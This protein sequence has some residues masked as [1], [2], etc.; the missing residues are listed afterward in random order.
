MIQRTPLHTRIQRVLIV[1][2]L[3]L[4]PL[5][6]LCS[7]LL[8]YNRIRDEYSRTMHTHINVAQTIL[9]EELRH[10]D[11]LVESLRRALVNR[12][13][14]ALLSHLV[15]ARLFN[16]M[17]DTF[18][19][20]DAEGRVIAI[21][22][23]Y[24]EY[25]G[26]DFSALVP[27][28]KPES[29][30]IRY[31]QSLLTTQSVVAI[32]YPFGKG[33]RLVVERPADKFVP[34]MASFEKAK[35]Y[36]GE[37]FFVLCENGLTVYHPDRELI[38]T[39]YNFGFE[40]K[41]RTPM[42]KEGFFT[43]ISHSVKYLAL[44]SVF[45]DPSNW[46]MYYAIPT[47]VLTDE[48]LSRLS[49]QFL[50]LAGLLFA[51]LWVLG[52]A[53]DR[54]VT[55]PVR[56][57]VRSLEQADHTREFS[58][59]DKDLDEI[60]EF[61][62]I[63]DAVVRR[64]RELVDMF[65]RFSAVLNSLQAVVYVVDMNT[66][67]VLFINSYARNLVGDCIGK[68][69][70]LSFHDDMKE[71]CPFCTNDQLVDET[72][73]PAGS[74]TTE[75]YN[76]KV[77]R[78]YDCRDQAI[79][80][81]DGR[82][83]RLEVA[84]D[85]TERKQAEERLAA[86]KERLEVTLRSIG[87][88]VITT[89]VEGRVVYV[90][91]VAEEMTGWRNR[92]ALGRPAIEVFRIINEKTGQPSANPV[93]RVIELGRIVGLANH[94]AL[95]ARDGTVRSI[96]DSGAPIRDRKGNIIGVVL[97][98]RDISK[99]RKMEEELLKIRKLESV[100]VLAGGIAHDF[101]NILAAILGNV[102]LLGYRINNCDAEVT[103]VLE[104]TKRAIHRAAKLTRQLLTFS[105]GGDP[106]KAVT[107]LPELIT[108]SANFVLHGSPVRCRFRFP[109]N[110][111]MVDV[112][113]GQLGQVIQNIVLNG[114]HAMP[115]GG[116]ITIACANVLDVASESLLS[117]DRGNYVRISINDTGVGI[118]REITDK[119]FD[120]YFTTKQEGSGLGL[121][122]CHSI[123]NKHDG[124]LTVESEPG[125]GATF[126][127]YLPAL[128]DQNAASNAKP[129]ITRSTRWARIMV[130]DDEEMLRKLA[131]SQLTILGHK[132]ILV[133]DG[134]EAVNRYQELQ[135]KGTPVDVVI[136]DL[137]IPGG[138]GGKEAGEQLLAVDPS[139]RIIVTSGYSNDP[140]MASFC[141][142]GFK[143]AIEKPFN[144]RELSAAIGAALAP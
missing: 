35:R 23:P 9:R 110:L 140:V 20:L 105:K 106:V 16:L 116:T 6:V 102:E 12:Q 135:D 15:N 74:C 46:V 85:I 44:S 100:G 8:E 3:A 7:G 136:L 29:R 121:A 47:S 137:T 104:E 45:T 19:L 83:V 107:S 80:W 78:W 94:T 86:E 28:S 128:P 144:L 26:L 34:M 139:A 112:D 99:E 92:E 132:P 18:Y 81:I 72:G 88:G 25:L 38:R 117:V 66:Y 14:E 127:I 119:I 68:I 62:S 123:I 5:V 52:M 71:P 41:H 79:E 55:H 93:Q 73:K 115:G 61:H 90:N 30:Q 1:V 27:W 54:F 40:L 98:F 103:A 24:Q 13:D 75:F 63:T 114:V 77:R 36:E 109:E 50:F 4:F 125:Q 53:F 126:I 70:Y 96:A 59:M 122:I 31:Y 76:E 67:E 131:A 65:S 11:H 60:D 82:I 124:F 141:Q 108:E 32:S 56:S 111:W 43:F 133:E 84:I 21:S 58:L 2:I 120:P 138:M 39:R 97:V 129:G 130:M 91:K 95:I 118:P 48:L 37:L 143:A 113:S 17:G 64:D 51:L 10:V 42:D 142:Y 49:S 69:C 89:D 134:E 22:K 101:N 33:R 87:D 57:L